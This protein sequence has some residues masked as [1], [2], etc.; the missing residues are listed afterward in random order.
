MLT[1]LYRLSQVASDKW[2]IVFF[3]IRIKFEILKNIIKKIQK[4][5]QTTWLPVAPLRPMTPWGPCKP[6]KPIGPA[7]PGN[8]IRPELPI[9]PTEPF[10]LKNKII[11]TFIWKD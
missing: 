7:V 6:G 10:N 5:W 11:D 2:H 9:S 1:I 8:P 4:Y 3:V